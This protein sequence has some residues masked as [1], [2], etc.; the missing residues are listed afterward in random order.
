MVLLAW[1]LLLT[2]VD[3]F[4]YDIAQA[5][6]NSQKPERK[7]IRQALSPNIE[8]TNYMNNLNFFVTFGNHNL[9]LSTKTKNINKT[10]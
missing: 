5:T 9:S 3:F 6:P 7:Y 2:K 4:K 8:E 1:L 10:I